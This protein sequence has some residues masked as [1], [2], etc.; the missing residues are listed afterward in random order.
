MVRKKGAL[1]LIVLGYLGL[2]KR[3]REEDVELTTEP[4]KG[5][6]GGGGGAR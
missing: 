6:G 3:E 5:F 1:L 2:A 4:T